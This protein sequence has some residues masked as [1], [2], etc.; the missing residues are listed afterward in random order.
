[1]QEKE[2]GVKLS[3]SCYLASYILPHSICGPH[4][5]QLTPKNIYNRLFRL[6]MLNPCSLCDA[7]AVLMKNDEKWGSAL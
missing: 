1:M 4:T 5:S 3:N 7:Y 6:F 2:T